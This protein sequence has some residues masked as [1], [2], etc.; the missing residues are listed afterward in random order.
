MKMTVGLLCQ[1]KCCK[2]SKVT[3]NCENFSSILAWWYISDV[4]IRLRDLSEIYQKFQEFDLSRQ[5]LKI[6]SYSSC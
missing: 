1:V 3:Q 6:E 2:G 5:F 4:K